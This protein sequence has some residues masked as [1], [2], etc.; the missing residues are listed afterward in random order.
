MTFWLNNP[1]ILLNRYKIYEV[2]PYEY[3]SYEEKLNAVTRTLIYISILLFFI[4]K[5]IYV[6]LFFIICIFIIISLY[7]KH[8]SVNIKEGYSSIDNDDEPIENNNPFNNSILN[9]T[10]QN[11]IKKNVVKSDSRM[12]KTT[13]YEIEYNS[14]VEKKIHD[15]VKNII[16]NNNKDNKDIDKIFYNQSDNIDFENHMR[17]FYI[18]P[19]N[20]D[21]SDFLTYCYGSLPSN[22]S[23]I[24][25]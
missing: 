11:I 15:N 25:Y 3:L 21:L 12:G 20:N 14:E 8:V 7:R 10:P 24:S 13:S 9:T 18:Q 19:I 6:I 5:S 23:V 16:L 4:F 1:S 2:V 22:K 17:Q